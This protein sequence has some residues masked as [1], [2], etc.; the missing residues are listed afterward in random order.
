MRPNLN[1]CARQPSPAMEEASEMEEA[2]DSEEDQE[3]PVMATVLPR[4]Q[5]AGMLTLFV[6]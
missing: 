3:V 4:H 2:E 5:P 6:C 1:V